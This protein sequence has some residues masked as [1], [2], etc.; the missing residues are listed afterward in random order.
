M[1]SEGH[2]HPDNEN[3]D[4]GRDDDT[5]EPNTDDEAEDKNNEILSIIDKQY[6][7]WTREKCGL[8]NENVTSPRRCA[9]TQQ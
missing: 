4:T 1:A 5:R 2:E 6:G 3:K 9:Y 8:G 7:M